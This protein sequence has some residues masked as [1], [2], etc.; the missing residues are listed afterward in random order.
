MLKRDFFAMIGVVLLALAIG[1][2]PYITIAQLADGRA[3]KIRAEDV[4]IAGL[5]L[6][7]FAGFL[8]SGKRTIKKAPLGYFILAW[9][10]IHFVST[11]AD[12]ILTGLYFSRSFFFF[13]KEVE[14]FAIYFYVF[15]RR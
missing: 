7:S 2:S 5:L 8:I 9:L 11:M 15:W 12:F 13:L 14:F 1:L 3:V 6:I 4:F 10:G